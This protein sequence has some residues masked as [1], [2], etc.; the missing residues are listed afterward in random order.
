MP[1]RFEGEPD[2]FAE[3]VLADVQNGWEGLSPQAKETLVVPIP[4][5]HEGSYLDPAGPRAPWKG[6]A[7]GTSDQPWCGVDL[8]VLENWSFVEADAGPAAGKIRIWYQDDNAATDLGTAN[9]LMTEMEAK[10]WPKLTTLMGREPLPDH[11][12]TSGCQGE[13]TRSTSP[14]WTRV[15]RASSRRPE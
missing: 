11:G 10:I 3:S 5:F 9:H 1:E 7:R 6:A 15:L 8:P 4:P 12:G 14:W 2:S 13:A